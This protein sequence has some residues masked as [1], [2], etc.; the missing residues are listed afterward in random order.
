M[1]SHRYSVQ[2][3]WT[4]NEGAGTTNYRSYR[5]D[6]EISAQGKAPVFGSS[7]PAF[8]GDPARYNPEELLV[9]ALSSCH[10]LWYLH[11][12]SVNGVVVVDY[13]D[14]ASGVMEENADGS[15]Q[16][17]A[18]TLRPT[19]RLAAGSDPV[20]A[21]RLHGE[22]HRSCFLARSINFPVTIEPQFLP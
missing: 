15:G 20:H 10:M 1:K 12:C 13:A 21:S 2:M 8:R 11:L 17:V 18:V 7:D 5:R 19:V 9:A 14:A 3:A 6:Y 22:A 16:F 4:G